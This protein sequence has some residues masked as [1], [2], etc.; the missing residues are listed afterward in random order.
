MAKQVTKVDRAEFTKQ[1]GTE[2]F[3]EAMRSE[4]SM[5]ARLH[6]DSSLDIDH[7][8]E[9]TDVRDFIYQELDNHSTKEIE[10]CFDWVWIGEGPEQD[11]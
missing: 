11:D 8:E 7:L 9:I 6:E 1:I 3:R 10:D 5:S 2:S 4:I